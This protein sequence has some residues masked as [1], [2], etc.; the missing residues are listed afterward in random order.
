[1]SDQEAVIAKRYVTYLPEYGVIVCRN[2]K[3]AF[4]PRIR[5]IREHFCDAHKSTTTAIRNTISGYVGKLLLS[6]VKDVMT[7]PNN[8]VGPFHPGDLSVTRM[9]M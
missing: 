1:M 4:R 7:P 2:C 8:T 9:D 5:S 3:H 6:E